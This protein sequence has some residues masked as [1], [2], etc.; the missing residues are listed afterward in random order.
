LAEGATSVDDFVCALGDRSAAHEGHFVPSRGKTLEEPVDHH[1]CAT[2]GWMCEV[3]PIDGNYL[4]A[5]C[6][7]A[8][9]PLPLGWPALQRANGDATEST[10]SPRATPTVP[11]SPSASRPKGT[12]SRKF[13]NEIDRSSTLRSAGK[14]LS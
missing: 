10:M 11:A 13:E 1:L 8:M 4:Q 2:C 7:L 9:W 12:S 3:T 6:T 14:R 5:G